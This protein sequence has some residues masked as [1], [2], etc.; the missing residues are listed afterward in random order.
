MEI[1]IIEGPG[2]AVTRLTRKAVTECEVCERAPLFDVRRDITA[3]R[4]DGSSP[5]EAQECGRL[6]ARKDSVKFVSEHQAIE[7]Y[8]RRKEWCTQFPPQTP[9]FFTFLQQRV[10]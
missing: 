4:R 9:P 2:I 7:S 8:R 6:M 10:W 5:L 3:A 1:E